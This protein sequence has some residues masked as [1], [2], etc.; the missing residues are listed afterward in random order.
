MTRR[1]SRIWQPNEIT[2][3]IRSSA[4]SVNN[5]RQPGLP[6]HGGETQSVRGAAARDTSIPIPDSSIPTSSP[7]SEA[8]SDSAT[9]S[10]GY[11]DSSIG[12]SHSEGLA[13]LVKDC[14]EQHQKPPHDTFPGRIE[15]VLPR[16]HQSQEE[17]D[18]R[19]QDGD[20]LDSGKGERRS[21]HDCVE[22]LERPS[23]E[24]PEESAVRTPMKGLKRTSS[25]FRLH[26][27]SDGKA[28]VILEGTTPSPPSK[29]FTTVEPPQPPSTLQGTQ[30]DPSSCGPLDAGA[31]HAIPPIPRR[32]TSGRSRDV[33]TWEFYCDS[34]ARN[35]LTE[36]AEQERQGS[37]RAALALIRSSSGNGKTPRPLPSQGDAQRQPHA[38]AKKRPGDQDQDRRPKLART[39]SSVARLQS[40]GVNV[41]AL[42]WPAGGKSLERD[43]AKL[44]KEH[45][46]DSDKENWEPGTQQ[47]NVRR[48]RLPMYNAFDLHKVIF[49]EQER[50]PRASSIKDEVMAREA[51]RARRQSLASQETQD[52]GNGV[53]D[54]GGEVSAFMGESGRR[55]EELD[56][57]QNLLSLSQGHWR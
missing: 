5:D 42:Q 22:L 8:S 51:I 56:A 31:T 30:S 2:S 35:A 43:P 49:H 16:S 36:T 47:S 4:E 55:V 33:R 18:G 52:E 6:R 32:A 12:T 23:E 54:A 29:S 15:D 11:S 17:N 20:G 21:S 3:I 38:L 46:G 40:Q 24:K 1:K 26:T 10:L 19:A 7:H 13:P 9:P 41:P 44:A 25:F 48:R 39:T 27:D 28:Q 37:A 45:S 34:D 57:V 14:T 50:E 53:I